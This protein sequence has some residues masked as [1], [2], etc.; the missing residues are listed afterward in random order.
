VPIQHALE[1]E[2][3]NLTNVKEILEMF[4]KSANTIDLVEIFR[5]RLILKYAKENHYDF[6]VKGLNG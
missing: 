1:T 2:N 6:V 3:S 5:D 4:N